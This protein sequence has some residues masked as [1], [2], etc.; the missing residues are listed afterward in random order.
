MSC[1][2]SVSIFHLVTKQMAQFKYKECTLLY[3]LVIPNMNC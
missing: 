3:C 2:H 1:L